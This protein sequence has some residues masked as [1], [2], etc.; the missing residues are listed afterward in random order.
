[1]NAIPFAVLFLFPGDTGNDIHGHADLVK[2]GE[3][4]YEME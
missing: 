3:L 4:M 1:M 2:R